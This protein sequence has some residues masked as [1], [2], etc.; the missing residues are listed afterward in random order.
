VYRDRYSFDE[1]AEQVYRRGQEVMAAL[2][3]GYPGPTVLYT[4]SLSLAS[5]NFARQWL[6]T[7][8]YGLL[9]PF[10]EGMIGA[11]DAETILVDGF[12]VSYG[13][14]EEGQFRYASDLIRNDT[15]DN[16]A[17]DSE[18]YRVTMHVGFGLWLDHDCTEG[19]LP[20]GC[21]NGFTPE[22]FQ[23]ALDL[24]FQYSDG[25]VWI[26]SQRV[27]WYTGE[28]IPTEWQSVLLPSGQ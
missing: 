26:Y 4:Y 16:F 9:V 8:H 22:S 28:G 6:P 15:A 25:Y 24:A 14:S 7:F 19:L 27:N 11:A 5:Q 13:Y 18:R 20:T 17:R 12:E 3:R 2:N 1:Y 10:V 23:R 21:P